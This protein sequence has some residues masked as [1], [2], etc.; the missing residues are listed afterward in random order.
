MNIDIKYDHL[1]KYT[2]SIS[3][4]FLIIGVISLLSHM[5]AINPKLISFIIIY[6]IIGIICSVIAWSIIEGKN[7]EAKRIRAGFY[8]PTFDDWKIQE[9]LGESQEINN[10]L[11]AVLLIIFLLMAIIWIL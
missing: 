1:H 9:K 6:S 10:Y 8:N 3:T 5:E 7:N 2:L 11:F 4:I